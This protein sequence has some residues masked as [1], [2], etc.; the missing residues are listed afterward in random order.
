MIDKTKVWSNTIRLLREVNK[1][2]VSTLDYLYHYTSC[3]GFTGIINKEQT[4]SFW[5]TS[6]DCLNDSSEGNY[7]I[8][9]YRIACEELLKDGEIDESFYNKVIDFTPSTKGYINYL[10]N[11]YKTTSKEKATFVT[12]DVADIETYICCFS[13]KENSLDMWR[14]Y[15]NSAD[16]YS[17]KFNFLL[18]YNFLNQTIHNQKDYIDLIGRKV[19]YNQNEQVIITKQY[20]KACYEGCEIE[21]LWKSREE[22]LKYEIESFFNTYRF[23]FKHECFASENEYRFLLRLPAQKPKNMANNM[24]D[25]EYRKSGD[26]LI[27]YVNLVIKNANDYLE[28]VMISPFVHDSSVVEKTK[29]FVHSQGFKTNDISKSEL[30]VR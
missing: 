22:E 20:L 10:A 8:R 30:P 24:L 4:I 6:S 12:V 23:I 13:T 9:V 25:V 29:D 2:D 28:G 17:L 1:S 7:I 21:S 15:A 14:C 26:M 5:F 19:I 27:P 3:E 16:G 18:F 11:D